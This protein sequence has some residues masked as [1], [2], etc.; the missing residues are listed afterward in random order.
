MATKVNKKRK[1]KDYQ[2]KIDIVFLSLVLMLL[3]VGLV[4]LFS[5]SYAFSLEYYNN[6]Y[7]FISRQSLFAVVGVVA[8]LVI[9]RIDYHY[10]RKFAPAIYIISILMLLTLLVFPPM[11]WML[12]V[13]WL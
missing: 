6:S 12:N 11:V 8:M 3:T 7:K 4:M 10:W 1:T 5:A 9:S 13:G 2:G